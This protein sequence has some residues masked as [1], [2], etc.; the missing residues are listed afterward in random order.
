MYP[1]RA[2]A[3]PASKDVPIFVEKKVFEERK[4]DRKLGEPAPKW[5]H[6]LRH[7]AESIFLLLV[8]WAIHIMPEQKHKLPKELTIPSEIWSAIVTDRARSRQLLFTLSDDD[9]HPQFE[10]LES[11]LSVLGAQLMEDY[12]WAPERN[13]KDLVFVHEAMQRHIATFMIDHHNAAFMDIK[14][15]K[16]T[17]PIHEI[18]T[19]HD[20]EPSA[21]LNILPER[22]I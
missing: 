11:L 20:L 13:M 1:A 21:H 7:D 17:R 2:N 16:N 5:E 10:E 14:I 9:L 19:Y 22:T 18:Q 4:R 8:Y 6:D 12:E 15:G 3:F